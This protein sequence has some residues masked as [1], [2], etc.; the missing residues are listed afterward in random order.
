MKYL[1]E[2]G[3]DLI[4]ACL[5]LSYE[6]LPCDDIGACFQSGARVVASSHVAGVMVLF[7]R[8][9]D[10]AIHRDFIFDSADSSKYKDTNGYLFNHE[11]QVP[12]GP[13]GELLQAI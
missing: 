3:L 7:V 1:S 9:G 13:R 4:P 5:A 8:T 2:E 10:S 12:P 6:S 11:D